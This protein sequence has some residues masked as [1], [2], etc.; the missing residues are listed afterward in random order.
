ML[1][2]CERSEAISTR[3]M[4]SHCERS[5]AISTRQIAP[6]AYSFLLL[7]NRVVREDE[8]SRARINPRTNSA[9]SAFADCRRESPKGGLAI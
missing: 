8:S 7:R 9:K 2:H 4:P 3:E 6:D 1:S 5:E